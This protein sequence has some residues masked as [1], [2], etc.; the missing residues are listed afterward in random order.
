MPKWCL[1][2]STA[3]RLTRKIARIEETTLR[4]RFH[5]ERSFHETVDVRAEACC[6]LGPGVT[7]GHWP[8]GVAHSAPP[9]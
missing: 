7:G 1:L 3:K 8:K 2:N 5:G 9:C 4:D 6:A